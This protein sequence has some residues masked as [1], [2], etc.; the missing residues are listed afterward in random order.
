MR[1]KAR[2]PRTTGSPDSFAR[3]LDALGHDGRDQVELVGRLGDR[4]AQPLA[5]VDDRRDAER[6]Q[7]GDDENRNCAAQ[8]G[9]GGE[10]RR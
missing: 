10:S 4:L 5:D 6:D 1:S 7:E 8:K 9:F 3:A 2:K